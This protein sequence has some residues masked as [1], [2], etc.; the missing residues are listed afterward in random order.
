MT[1]PTTTVRTVSQ[2]NGVTTVWPFN[3]LIR[4]AEEVE[5]SVLV[6]GVVT[7]I[8]PGNYSVTGLGLPGGGSITYPLS[9]PPLAAPAQIA[10]R[11]N[12]DYKQNLSLS[13]QNDF[14]PK[15]LE[16]QGF[17][18]VVQQ[19]QD[20]KDK[21]DRTLRFNEFS[22]P[23]TPGYL[24]AAAA[25]ENRTLVFSA[26]GE[27]FGLGPT[28]NEIAGA[29]TSALVAL[30]ARDEAA[31]SAASI[32]LPLLVASGGTGAATALA[33]RSNLGL[34]IGVD[35]QAYNARLAALAALAGGADL[36][37]YMTGA[38]TMGQTALSGFAR[39][40]LDDANAAAART[41]LGATAT[42]TAAFT[43]A[44]AAALRTAAGATAT[45]SSLLTAADAAAARGAIAAPAIPS[46]SAG[47]GQVAL[48]NPGFGNAFVTPAGGTWLVWATQ[49]G[50]TGLWA[51][52]HF[53]D[54]VGGGTSIGAP[55]ASWAWIGFSWRVQG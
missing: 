27:T 20:L 6:N 29:Q 46:M 54:I 22:F 33:A 50:N 34:E 53:F 11:R 15:A 25:R 5:V 51:F 44:D 17:D 23:V 38:G 13:N 49:A 12:P 10:I 36:L 31:A 8:S 21:V 47:P 19:T 18:A 45:G 14:F 24:P 41:T 32:A 3:F 4:K 35:V 39:S 9:G 16:Q 55:G 7:V 43:A 48:V 42:G 30:Q 1:I 40:L 28:G 2:A 26:D 37:P 52:T